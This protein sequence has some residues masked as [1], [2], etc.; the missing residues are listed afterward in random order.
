MTTINKTQ[1]G[2][3]EWDFEAF[4]GPR[5]AVLAMWKEKNPRQDNQGILE[6]LMAKYLWDKT[7]TSLE[8]WDKYLA[9]MLDLKRS[10]EIKESLG[11]PCR[12]LWEASQREK[13]RISGKISNGDYSGLHVSTDVA[14]DSGTSLRLTATVGGWSG[15]RLFW[16]LDAKDTGCADSDPIKVCPWCGRKLEVTI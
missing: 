10:L 14:V 3:L 12:K 6:E 5:E 7:Q 9:E 11:C 2:K 16:T 8:V 4:E 1:N 13:T 15:K